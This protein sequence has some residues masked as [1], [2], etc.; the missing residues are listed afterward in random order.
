MKVKAR[1]A[2]SSNGAMYLQGPTYSER[3]TFIGRVWES[4]DGWWYGWG[5]TPKGKALLSDAAD[6]EAKARERVEAISN[7]EVDS[8]AS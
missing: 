8:E 5:L 3:F 2:R 1:W 6:T 7:V 4:M